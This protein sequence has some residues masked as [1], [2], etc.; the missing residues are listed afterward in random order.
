[1][2][3]ICPHNYEID[4]DHAKCDRCGWNP[5]VA[6]KRIRE[7]MKTMSDSKLY[8]I[9]FTGWCEV[10]AQS[11]EEALKQAED[12]QMFTVCYDLGDPECMEEEEENELD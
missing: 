12:E 11:A 2:I 10:W 3:R 1:M 4:C 8:R 5:E 7:A 6:K 9:P